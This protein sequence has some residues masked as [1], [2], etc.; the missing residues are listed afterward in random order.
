M[1]LTA[2]I[3]YDSPDRVTWE[4]TLHDFR[5]PT[6]FFL[7]CEKKSKEKKK[8]KTANRRSEESGLT[9]ELVLFT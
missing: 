7:S 1:H 2:N 8:K 9:S 4:W 6:V 3:S 5:L